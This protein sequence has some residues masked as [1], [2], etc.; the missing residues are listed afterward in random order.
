M[1]SAIAYSKLPMRLAI[2]TKPTVN[3]SF[4]FCLISAISKLIL[5]IEG[6]I[7]V[8]TQYDIQFA[9][10]QTTLKQV[11]IFRINS[12][13]RET[14]DTPLDHREKL[15]LLADFSGHILKSFCLNEMDFHKVFVNPDSIE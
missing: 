11:I 12:L 5:G 13:Q 10:A 7:K 6:V 15:A 3:R 4:I 1:I 2:S 14:G 8:N 9:S